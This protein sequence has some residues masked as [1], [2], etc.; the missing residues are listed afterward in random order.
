MVLPAKA[1]EKRFKYEQKV[2]LVSPRIT[3]EGK[4][5]RGRGYCDVGTS[6]LSEFYT[7]LVPKG[8]GFL[9]AI[10][11]LVLTRQDGTATSKAKGDDT[12]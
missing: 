7:P 1:G 3:G 2:K 8:Q 11:S 10:G 6:I 9:R 4:N 12:D 5:V